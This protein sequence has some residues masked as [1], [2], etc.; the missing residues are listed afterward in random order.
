MEAAAASSAPHLLH[1]GGF[2]RL[3]RLASLPGR[4]GRRPVRRVLAVATEPKP[5]APAP[6]SRPRTPNDISSTV[7]PMVS[8]P[9]CSAPSPVL[10]CHVISLRLFVFVCLF[11]FALLRMKR[12]GEVSKEIQ[13]VRKQMEEDEQLATLMRG[14]RGQ[15]LRDSQFA[16]D[17]VRLRLVEVSSMNNNEALPLVYSPEIISAYWGK[18]PTAVATRVVQLLSVAG[19]FISHLI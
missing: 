19:G 18:R 6:R 10:L 7:R 8:L 4:R 1:C 14:L 12:F 17:N 15:N 2:G 3:P 9:A 5:S 11:G 16:D 13:R